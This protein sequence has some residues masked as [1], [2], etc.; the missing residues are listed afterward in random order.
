MENKKYQS[1]D[2]IATTTEERVFLT[3]IEL[4]NV[5]ESIRYEL[6]KMNEKK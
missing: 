5:L 2:F 3:N 6:W 1:G 4:L